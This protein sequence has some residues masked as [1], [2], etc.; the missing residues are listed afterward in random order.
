[1]TET[2]KT[3]TVREEYEQTFAIKQAKEKEYNSLHRKAKYMKQVVLFGLENKLRE[4]ER[5]MYKK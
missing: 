5:K 1:M 3:M 4:L 2:N